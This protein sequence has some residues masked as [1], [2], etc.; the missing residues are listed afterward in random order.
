[1]SLPSRLLG[2]N[3]SIQVSSLL[4]GSFSTPSAKESFFNNSYFS[5][6]STRLTSSQNEIEFAS[7]SQDYTHLQLRVTGRST[8]AYSYS[9]VYLTFNSDTTNAY[10][11]SALYSI[12]A[13]T[14]DNSSRGLAGDNQVVT[15]NIAGNNSQPS[16]VGAIIVDIFNYKNTNMN[17]T[18][19]SYGGFDDEVS[20][21]TPPRTA[22][23]N[24]SY[25][26][27][28]SAITNIKV[29]TDGD[30]APFTQVSL[31]GIKG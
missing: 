27:N 11:F 7:I 23:I 4:S 9:S 5:I 20:S 31:Y 21:F 18:V 6:A 25:W 13:S 30:F 22:N 29:R 24:T 19:R 1:M 15:Q 26:A 14:A 28:T 16:L 2:A 17:T 3:P 12:N 10:S 8:G